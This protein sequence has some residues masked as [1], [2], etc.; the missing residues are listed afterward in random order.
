MSRFRNFI[1]RPKRAAVTAVLAVSLAASPM[2]ERI[3]RADNNTAQVQKNSFFSSSKLSEKIKEISGGTDEKLCSLF[4]LLKT[5]NGLLKTD[6]S[7][8]D[9]RSPRNV[10]ETLEKGGDCTELSFVAITAM[11]ELGI[12]GGADVV[13]FKGKDENEHHMVAFAYIEKNGEKI[14]IHLDPQTDALGKMNGEYDLVMEL[15]F[16][17]AEGMYHRE[18]GNYYDK[19]GKLGNAIQSFEKAI[20]FNS[21]DAYCHHMLGMLYKEKYDNTKSVD[22]LV[23]ARDYLVDAAELEPKNK[24]YQKDKGMAVY[25]VE[26]ELAFQAIDKS[27]YKE[28][29]QHFKNALNCGLKLS[30]EDEKMLKDYIKQC[31][32]LVK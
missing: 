22:D 26:I 20:E 6:S 5:G 16:E 15:T 11:K 25:T 2:A 10:D 14:K 1:N 13:H 4:K 30:K 29:K 17:Q 9:K 28:A 32:Q 24:K 23:K 31:D 12:E 18:M 21:K 27:D 3:A 8:G 19:K 7:K